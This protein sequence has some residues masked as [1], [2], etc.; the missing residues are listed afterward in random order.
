MLALSIDRLVISPSKTMQ[1]CAMGRLF[2]QLYHEGVAKRHQGTGYKLPGAHSRWAGRK[3]CRRIV[4]FT[5]IPHLLEVR[6][7]L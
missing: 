6:M 1:K 5:G 4:T 3:L 2:D 7:L